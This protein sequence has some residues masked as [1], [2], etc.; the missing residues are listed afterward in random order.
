MAGEE[1]ATLIAVQV[2]LGRIEGVLSTVVTEHSRR[3][4]DNAK[5]TNKVRVDLEAQ[6]K[7]VDLKL[8]NGKENGNKLLREID[9]RIAANTSTS[10]ENKEDIREI[11]DK[12]DSDWGKKVSITG[13]LLAG[14]AFIWPIIQHR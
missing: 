5:E 11:R 6:I 7:A 1:Q 9:G 10:V 12:Q 14:A 13:L 4:E 8:E 3:I 2:Q